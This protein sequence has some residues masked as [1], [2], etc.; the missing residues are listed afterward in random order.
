VSTP[1]PT[2][3][4]KAVA[5]MFSRIVPWYDML[6]T[7]LSLGIDRY[8]RKRLVQEVRLGSTGTVLDLAA[9]TLDVS[10]AI[11]RRYSQARVP[12]LDFCPPMLFQGQK[13]L[14]GANAQAIS[15]VAADAK[16]LPLPDACVDAVTMAFG[17]RNIL[18]RHEAFAEMARV[19][20]PGG[21]ACILEFGSGK[22]RVWGGV[23]NVYLDYILPRIGKIISQDASAY[24]YLADTIRNFPVAEALEEEMREAGFAA[25]WHIPLTSG[26]V[27]LHI[28]EKARS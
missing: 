25:A 21:R 27:C 6:N 23:Y 14:R 13:K 19:L 4:G 2:G 26:I 10:L 17:I 20:V 16:L 22:Q 3:H 24:T 18:P 7:V 1:A 8:W 12:A 15:P 5:S 9:G 11:R 28:A